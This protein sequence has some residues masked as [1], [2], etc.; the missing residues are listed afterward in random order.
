[1][2]I[3]M[4]P[5]E[6]FEQHRL[7]SISDEPYNEEFLIACRNKAIEYDKEDLFLR[8]ILLSDLQKSIPLH[9]RGKIFDGI[10]F[11]FVG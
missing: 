6:T 4:A 7:R 2:A 11:I 3:V 9:F 1:M 5:F 8:G 10:S